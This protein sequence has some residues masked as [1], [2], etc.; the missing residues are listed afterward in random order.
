[1]SEE[2]KMCPFL[3]GPCIEHKCKMWVML[4]GNNPQTGKE[5]PEYDCSL[6]WLPILM[7]ENQRASTG[8]QAATESFRN[9]LT[10]IGKDM[11]QS[12][13]ESVELRRIEV[14]EKKPKGL[15]GYFKKD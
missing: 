13:K 4:L 1:M 6:A 5:L 3:N 9:E 10:T 15:L 2:K 8:I 14:L 11:V 12:A 7:V